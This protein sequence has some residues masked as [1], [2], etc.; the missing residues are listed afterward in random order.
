MTET[1]RSWDAALAMGYERITRSALGTYQTAV[2]RIGVAGTWLGFLL[3]EWPNRHELYGP[4]GPLSSDLAAQRVEDNG[5][6]TVLLW[7]DSA[8]WFELSYVF[9]ILA[10]LMLLL[11]WRTRTA[12]VLFMIG[13]LS[14]QNR[15]GFISDGGDNVLHL[16]AIYL[17]FV[18]CGE[19][20][21]LD[22]M[23][24]R[25]AGGSA[26]GRRG[27][28]PDVAGVLLWSVLA[29]AALTAWAF[30]V[31]G[32]GWLLV[33]A[34][35]L[36]VHAVWWIVDRFT[37]GEPRAVCDMTTNLV[38]NGAVL[39]IIVQVCLLYATAGWFKVQG[40]RWQ[41]GTAAYYPL[42]VDVFTPWPALSDA[43]SAYGLP[44]L[45]MTYGTVIVQVAFPFTLFNRPIK[46]VVLACL[47][48]EHIGI[49]I[50]LG[51]PFFSLAIISADLIFLPTT[52]LRRVEAKVGGWSARWRGPARRRAESEA[53]AD[54]AEAAGDRTSDTATPAESLDRV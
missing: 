6:F 45:L 47:I 42:Q 25:R 20:F 53:D 4:E 39:V 49:A 35:L 30:G 54:D 44:I 46:N 9:A 18:R 10:S 31:L 29:L 2:V 52:L 48:A 14:V 50:L 15:N 43:V 26:G 21:S 3:R 11:G 28:R 41:D 51:L 16:M 8:W 5:A 23:F 22:A 34:G 12:S 27:R 24:R 1:Q 19:R 7:S 33:F 13:V 40:S 17:V 38:H 37:G 36:A 32:G